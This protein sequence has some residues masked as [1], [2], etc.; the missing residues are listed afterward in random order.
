MADLE[1]YKKY[2]WTVSETNLNTLPDDAPQAAKD[3]AKRLTL[4]G[5]RRSLTEWLSHVQ[6]DGRI[7]G[8]FWHIGAWTH[9]MSHSAPNQ[10]NIPA[11]WPT[12][13]DHNKVLP[14]T[15]VEEVKYKYDTDLRGC[16][17]VP[18]ESWLV[19]T[20]AEGIQLRILAHYMKSQAY[21]DAITKGDKKY[22]TD[23]HN[24]N[25]RALGTACKDRDTAKTFIYAW[26]LGAGIAKIAAILQCS[27]AI[28]RT[29]EQRFLDS[30]PELKRLKQVEIK[31]DAM[32]G[33][34]IGLDGRKV[35][36]TS[37]HLM[38]AGYL[39]NGEAVIMKKAA[40]RWVSRARQEGIK[41][42]LVD[43]V[44]DEWQT[45]VSGSYEDAVRLG[46]LQRQAIEEV[47]VELGLFC[48]LAGATVIGKNWAE[49]H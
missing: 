48:P 26:L 32:R 33:Y 37:D 8:K 21:V 3:L 6:D 38:L 42:K 35:P 2:G 5:R 1:H 30:L 11:N 41:F 39:Q 45:E 17:K 9:R 28:A 19:G 34:F 15:S 31:R 43:F 13:K 18:D 20:D 12:D 23:I 44:H 24:L 40:L 47:G 27:T 22:E 46:E 14:K 29:S 49:T 10:A 4:E 25:K 7:H 16:F 36:C